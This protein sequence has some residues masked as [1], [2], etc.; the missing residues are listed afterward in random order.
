VTSVKSIIH[1][2]DGVGDSLD[3]TLARV[4]NCQRPR[5][6]FYVDRVIDSLG[7][8]SLMA[9]VAAIIHTRELYLKEPSR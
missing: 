4:R 7:A 2:S 9:I 3:G 8:M 5:H 1:S 6:G